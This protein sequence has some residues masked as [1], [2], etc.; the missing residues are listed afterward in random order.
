[1]EPMRQKLLTID[2]DQL[3]HALADL[4]LSNWRDQ[5]LSAKIA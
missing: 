2:D 4:H 1:M 3:T 5:R